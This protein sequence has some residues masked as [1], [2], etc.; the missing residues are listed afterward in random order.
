MKLFAT[1][2]AFMLFSSSFALAAI[3]TNALVTDLQAQGYTRV[4]VKTGPT[5]TKVEAIRGTEK[6]EVV[7][8]SASG[9]VLKSETEAVRP[10][11]DISPGVSIRNRDRDFLGGGRRGH[12]DDSDDLNDDSDD[13]SDDASDDSGDSGDDDHGDDDHGDDDHGS[14][15]DGGRGHGGDDS[16]GDD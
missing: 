3:D 9:A 1:T 6:V 12:S 8:D 15:H 13:S 10:G 14:D 2:A 5:Q 16:G 7:Y 4:E 11:D